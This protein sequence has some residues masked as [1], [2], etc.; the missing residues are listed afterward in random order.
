MIGLN[1]ARRGYAGPIYGLAIGRR[2]YITRTLGIAVILDLFLP[3]I[4]SLKQRYQI[5]W[6]T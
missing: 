5:K 3:K 1:I 4:K 2:G 6:L